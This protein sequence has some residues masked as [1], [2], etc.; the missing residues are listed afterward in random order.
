M[1]VNLKH[2]AG[3]PP[4]PSPPFHFFLDAEGQT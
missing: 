1:S 4:H 2:I 3:V